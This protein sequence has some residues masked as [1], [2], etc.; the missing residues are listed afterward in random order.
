MLI[1]V[2]L[3]FGAVDFSRFHPTLTFLSIDI[4]LLGILGNGHHHCVRLA[5]ILKNDYWNARNGVWMK[6]SREAEMCKLVR[7]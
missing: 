7:R 3:N 2:G 1:S 6:E 5:K 4:F